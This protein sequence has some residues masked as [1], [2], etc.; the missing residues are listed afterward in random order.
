[1]N[2]RSY[3]YVP[4]DQPDKLA[5][6]SSRGADALIADLEDAVPPAAKQTARSTVAAYLSGGG[7][8][9]VRVNAGAAAEDLAAIAGCAGL[10]GVVVPKAEP[11]LL[12]EVDE[13]LGERPIPVLAMV[14][15][16]RG[17]R[18]LDEVA[19]SPRVVRLGIGEADLAGEL[20]LRLDAD[21]TQLWPVRL[22][23]VLASAAAG[24]VPP[25]GPVETAVRDLGRLRTTTETLLHQGFRARTTLT[26]AQVDV[27]NSVFTPT[28]EEI[29]AARRVVDRLSADAVWIDDDG[30]FV[31]AAVVRT[32]QDVLARA[33]AVPGPAGSRRS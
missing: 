11:A 10:Q 23:L 3:L 32:A 9:W 8:A 16:A 17:I 4:G 5:K 18:R 31:D 21:R 28:T 26:P 25:A 15:T 22:E 1:M 30:R 29:A 33:D 27:V 24:L 12:S 7:R 19:A 20:G 13:L 14:E 6:A 2:P